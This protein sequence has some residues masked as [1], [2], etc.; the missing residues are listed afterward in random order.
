MK[1]RDIPFLMAAVAGIT[2]GM[3]TSPAA[4]DEKKEDVKCWGVN[5]CGSHAKCSVTAEDLGAFKALLGDQE[6]AA[7][8][9]KSEAHSCGSHAKCGASSHILN[10]TPTSADACKTQGGFLVEQGADKK[11]VAKKA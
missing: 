9:G 4:A 6:F 10:W 1:K 7:R 5:S 2:V 8:Y 11:K 3:T